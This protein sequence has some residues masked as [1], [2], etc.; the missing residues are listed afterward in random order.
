[1]NEDCIRCRLCIPYCP[2]G[3]ISLDRAVN[4]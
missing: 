3:A 4:N 1:M 2:M